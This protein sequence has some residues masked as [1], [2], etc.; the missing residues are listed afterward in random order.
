MEINDLLNLLI[1]IEQEFDTLCDD[2][3]SD[4]SI[5][6]EN[7]NVLNSFNLW[8]NQYHTIFL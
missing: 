5:C 7:F 2:K 3:Y 6:H 4:N 1:E 8:N